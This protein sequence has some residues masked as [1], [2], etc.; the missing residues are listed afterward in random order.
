M[1]CQPLKVRSFG[2]Q[3]PFSSSQ[4]SKQAQFRGIRTNSVRPPLFSL[5]HTPLFRASL[6]PA[7][8]KRGK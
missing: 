2:A 6:R 8:E 7:V 4:G 5:V 3:Y 1:T